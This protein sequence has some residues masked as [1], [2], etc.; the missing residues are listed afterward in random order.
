[1]K[2]ILVIGDSFA[3]DW[4]VKY[5]DLYKGWPNLLAEKYTVT[6]LA[7]AGVGE[8]KIYK[9]LLTVADLSVYDL[10]IVAHTGPARIHSLRHPIHSND[11][12]HS[13]ADL[14]FA[15][16]EYHASRP[17][18]FLNGSLR[19]AINFFKYHYDPEYFELMY[20]LLRKEINDILA[21]SNS[22]VIVI[23]NMAKTNLFATEPV[24]VTKLISKEESGIMNH[25][26]EATNAL[27]FKHIDSLIETM[28]HDA[29]N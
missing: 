20:T 8:Y 9:Q 24:L 21:K 3:A 4:T 6:N 12:L 14:I 1:M 5:K 16:I 2:N 29:L 23:S 28:T 11:V 7:Q 22:K 26:N 19:A 15:D 10:V 13:N 25:M 18:N 27:M 17:W